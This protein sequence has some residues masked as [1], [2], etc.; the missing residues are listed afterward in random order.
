M[1]GWELKLN[2]L[3]ALGDSITHLSFS[4]MRHNAKALEISIWIMPVDK[5]DEL[6]LSVYV[7]ET[8]SWCVSMGKMNE[9]LKQSLNSGERSNSGAAETG[10]VHLLHPWGVKAI[11]GYWHPTVL[12]VGFTNIELQSIELPALWRKCSPPRFH[13]ELSEF[14]HVRGTETSKD[15]G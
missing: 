8:G 13:F 7:V 15:L 12:R 2:I 10:D 5:M 3:E 6:L 11:C 9:V 1:P 14:I 4:L